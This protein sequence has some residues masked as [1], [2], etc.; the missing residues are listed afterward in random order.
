MQKNSVICAGL[1]CID[2]IK[3]EANEKDENN[4]EVKTIVKYLLPMALT[5]EDIAI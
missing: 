5:F 2:I 1:S 3:Y 4:E